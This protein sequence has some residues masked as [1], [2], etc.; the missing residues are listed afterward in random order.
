MLALERSLAEDSRDAYALSAMRQVSRSQ[1]ARALF[2]GADDA[3][4]AATAGRLTATT[5]TRPPLSRRV[6]LEEPA[7][8][9]VEDAAIVDSEVE[10][11]ELHDGAER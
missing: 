10:R 3:N 9:G 1:H 7:V 5:F 2:F 11:R 4:A 8:G 6:D